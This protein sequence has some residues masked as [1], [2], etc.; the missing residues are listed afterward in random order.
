MS[1]VVTLQQEYLAMDGPR[2]IVE[3]YSFAEAFSKRFA[4]PARKATYFVAR[5]GAAASVR[6]YRSK[7]LEKRVEGDLHGLLV[8][9][10]HAG[11]ALFAVTRDL[12]ER[13]RFERELLFEGPA[14]MEL[15]DIVLSHN[16]KMLLE[17]YLPVPECPVGR[18]LAAGILGDNPRLAAAPDEL[19]AAAASAGTVDRWGPHAGPSLPHAAGGPGEVYLFGLGGYVQDRILPHFGRH[20]AAA[21]DY[22]AALLCRHA[23]WD[24][25]VVADHAVV[26]ERLAAAERP[27]VI[28]ATYHSSHV[29]IAEAVLAA[30]PGALVFI[31]KPPAVSAAGAERLA[32]LRRQGYWIDIG[33]N[34]RYAP[35][36][37]WL[38]SVTRARDVPATMVISVKENAVHPGHWY[39]WPTQ[40]TRVTGNLCHWIDLAWDLLGSRVTEA[41]VAGA[42]QR[43]I[44]TFTCAD[45]SVIAIAGGTDGDSLRGVQERIEYR[46]GDILAVVDDFTSLELTAAGR[47]R[48]HRFVRRDKGHDAMYEDLR[49]RWETG[50]PPRYPLEDLVGVQALVEDISR[51]VEHREGGLLRE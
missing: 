21:A 9:V 26:L 13:P 27:L 49:R 45:G 18:Q 50:G 31:E 51:R 44:A 2:R 6:K 8:R 5:E 28:V 24:F 19:V 10:T 43:T 1:D 23:R 14:E 29:P 32:E 4:H 35:L 41:F 3:T 47:H 20:V 16:T 42:D 22:R 33:Y 48:T 11:A 25:P 38:R 15:G 12:G 17:S 36:A 7:V 34:R 39:L 46:S 37:R 40:G 30:N